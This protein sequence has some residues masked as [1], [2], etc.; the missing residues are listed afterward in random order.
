MTDKAEEWSGE[1]GPP[2][3]LPPAWE[4]LAVAACSC[5]ADECRSCRAIAKHRPLIEEQAATEARRELLAKVEG[6]PGVQFGPEGEP[7]HRLVT[8]AAVR[9]LI[10]EQ[11]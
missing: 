2:G 9:R 1:L 4:A 6:L 8:R 7:D 11:P 3:T 5:G 10:E